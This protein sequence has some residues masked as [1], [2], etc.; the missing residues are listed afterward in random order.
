[1]P[2][3]AYQ[4]LSVARQNKVC[5]GG[6]FVWCLQVDEGLE[7]EMAEEGGRNDGVPA[8]QARPVWGGPAAGHPA[9]VRVTDIPR[10]RLDEITGRWG[11]TTND[12]SLWDRERL[13]R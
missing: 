8:R 5:Q 13:E 7:N 2:L 11:Y 9:V 10:A 3:R 6:V 4:C 1:M 12:I